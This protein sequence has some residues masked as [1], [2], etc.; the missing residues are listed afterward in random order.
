MLRKLFIGSLIVLF[1]FFM[2]VIAVWALFLRVPDVLVDKDGRPISISELQ[3]S[4]IW[5]SVSPIDYEL[6]GAKYQS[7]QELVAALKAL[8]KNSFLA[9]R[10]GV[11]A[12]DAEGKQVIL[13]RC[14]TLRLAI[15]SA[16]LPPVPGVGNERF[17]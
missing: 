3:R 9:I 5:I 8:P 16:G 6:N 11:D 15:E 13:R 12:S 7:Q 17:Q 1:V 4:I 14:K 2:L 10:W